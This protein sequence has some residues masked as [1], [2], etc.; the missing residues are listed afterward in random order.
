MK[1]IVA[2]FILV[3]LV[4]VACREEKSALVVF[5][6][7]EGAIN[8]YDPVSYYKDKP[9]KGAPDHT[10]QWENATWHFSSA[11]YCAYGM[12]DGHKAPTQPDAW[13]IVDNKLYFNYNKEVLAKWRENRDESIKKAVD[14][15][16]TVRK[17]PF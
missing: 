13:T 4:S 5:E 3:T 16:P 14:N 11:G 15:W 7:P 10:Y 1:K 9:V 2:Y 8:G 6:T 12:A 17:D